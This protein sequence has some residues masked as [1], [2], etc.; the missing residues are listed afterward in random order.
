MPT[1]HNHFADVTTL[2]AGKARYRALVRQHHPDTGG[3]TAMMQAIN[4][5]WEDARAALLDADD[6][7]PTDRVDNSPAA[8]ALRNQQIDRMLEA[9]E[10]SARKLA[11]D[12]PVRFRRS[13]FGWGYVCIVVPAQHPYRERLRADGFSRHSAWQCWRK[14]IEGCPEDAALMAWL[15]DPTK[16]VPFPD[17]P[18]QAAVGAVER[19]GI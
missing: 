17:P 2:E 14:P 18:A 16:P 8:V 19:L 1:E 6:P 9:I 7:A 10:A 3:D 5:Q 12:V 11:P 15:R 13:S 4:R